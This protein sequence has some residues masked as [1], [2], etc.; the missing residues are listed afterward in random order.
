VP[1]F[2]IG[3][4]GLFAV[5]LPQSY[6]WATAVLVDEFNAGPFESSLDGVKR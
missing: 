6:A 1:D 2:F 3:L 5:S 4:L